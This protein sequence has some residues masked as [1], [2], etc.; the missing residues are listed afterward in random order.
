MKMM[1]ARRATPRTTPT[2]MPAVGTPE[3]L[4]LFSSAEGEGVEDAGT[5]EAGV[6]VLD[7]SDDVEVVDESVVLLDVSE[8]VDE[9]VVDVSSEDVV[10][11][12]RLEEVER[13]DSLLLLL[14]AAE[15]LVVVSSS[16]SSSPLLDLVAAEPAPSVTVDCVDCGGLKALEIWSPMEARSS[17]RPCGWRR[18]TVS[19]AT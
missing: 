15:R 10:A 12:R 13:V 19:R 1:P 11:V 8:E 4:E 3:P 17:S 16:S 2:A 18:S 5:V 7:V 9:S 14:V 6:G